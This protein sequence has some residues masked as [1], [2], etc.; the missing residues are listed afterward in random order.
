MAVDEQL[1]IRAALRDELSGPIRDIR[2]ELRGLQR[3]IAGVNSTSALGTRSL[4]DYG[5][6]FSRLRRI[7]RSLVGSLTRVAKYGIAGVTAAAAGGVVAIYKVGSAYQDSLNTFRAVTRATTGQMDLVRKK[8]KQLGADMSLPATSAADAADA[9]TE[10][11]KG[12]LGVAESM[13]ASLGTLQLAAAAQVSG[14]QA[15]QIQAAALNQFRL[16]ADQAGMVADVL[17]NTANAASGEITD[18]ANALSYVG[19]VANAFKISITDTATAIGLLA[20]N[21][22]LSEKAGTAMRGMLTS[23]AKPTRKGAK[24]LAA[25]NVEAFDAQGNFKGLRYVTDALAQAK[26]RLSVQE[27]NAAA[28]MAFGR[29][30][31]AAIN[32]LAASG[33]GEWDKMNTA[34]GRGG[35]AADVAAAKMKG[36]HGAFQGLKSQ[37]ETVAIEMYERSSPAVEGFVRNLAS[38][39][40]GAA[41]R[42]MN[43]I[44]QTTSNIGMFIDELRNGS[45]DNAIFMFDRIF[46][47]TGKLIGPVH[48]LVGVVQDFAT[49]VRESILPALGEFRGLLVLLLVPLAAA[50]AL[51]GFAA[52]H[53]TL[54][55]GALVGL[56]AAYL[57]YKGTLVALLV[58]DRAKNV[59]DAIRLART[60]SV[61]AAIAGETA[62]TA[63]NNAV[64]LTAAQRARALLVAGARWLVQKAIVLGVWT[65]EIAVIGFWLALGVAQAIARQ[66][67]AG[68]IWL[69]QRAV[70][71]AVWVAELIK[72][73]L[74]L[75]MSGAVAI[76]TGVWTAAQWLLNFALSANP[77]GLIILAIVALVA[78]VVIAY[79]KSETFRGI[80]QGLWGGIQKLAH[81]VW[82]LWSRFTPLGIAITHTSD[83]INGAIGVWGG[84]RDAIGWVVDK[85]RD[86]V[87]FAGAAGRAL[88][89]VNPGKLAKKVGGKLNPF[90]D[91]RTPR[92][93]GG[94]VANTLGVAA[95]L[96]RSVPGRRSVTN[97]LTGS[98]ASSDHPHGRAVDLVGTGL[99]AYAQAARRAGAY[100]AFHGAGAG[101][102]LH[103][104]VPGSVR[105]RRGGQAIHVAAGPSGDT[106]TPRRG[107]GG[108]PRPPAGGV[109]VMPGGI[110]VAV[111]GSDLTP[112]DVAAAVAQGIADYAR[113]QEER[114]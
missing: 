68:A 52:D 96:D 32:A 49:I 70:M 75:A 111:S 13:D 112:D 53:T 89:K 64:Q 56:I 98:G 37:L 59:L 40:P 10:L 88:D 104:A 81:I 72:I 22:I 30:P 44:E 42:A 85:L 91:T 28:A 11:A 20:N 48:L 23:L 1:V 93:S 55:K 8:A 36:L 9:M 99:G 90:G 3:Q 103:M 2:G 26:G 66:V 17:A 43:F 57:L 71:A 87:H 82:T 65:A 92:A 12:G 110:S 69:A 15:A 105:P 77:I 106:A 83:I 19:P 38:K 29:E 35:G 41:N 34:V 84:I 24:G 78:A 80:V 101:R 62:A 25:L 107:R 5:L 79:Q 27:F 50:R 74:Y 18:V 51:L 60:V 86:I 46:G 63:A 97:V 76:A 21:G 94:N 95:G 114:G 67:A 4:N 6:G 33:A 102:H 54:L 16:S 73:G 7:S 14:A 109:L 61:S 113:D 47:G 58:L 100:A 31:L 108:P 39:I 45:T